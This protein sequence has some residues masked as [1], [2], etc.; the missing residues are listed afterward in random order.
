MSSTWKIYRTE[1]KSDGSCDVKMLCE[2]HSIELAR[3]IV[4]VLSRQ[5][6]ENGEGIFSYQI[7]KK[8][9]NGSHK[10]PNDLGCGA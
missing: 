2:T 10:S 6:Q 7:E 4:Q 3:E 5:A 9:Q 1:Q 8:F